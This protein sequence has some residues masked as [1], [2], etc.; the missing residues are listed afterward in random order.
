MADR[1]N[2][3]LQGQVQNTS[4]YG[5]P[6]Q[7]SIT[8]QDLGITDPGSLP[9]TNVNTGINAGTGSFLD[10]MMGESAFGSGGFMSNLP[11]YALGALSYLDQKKTNKLNR[12]VTNT[13]LARQTKENADYDAFRNSW[14]AGGGTNARPQSAFST[15][16]IG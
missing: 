14:G 11:G 3:I 4:N 2:P 15:N 7:E 10:N 16:T 1:I 9:Y 5:T 6:F 12:K 13:N 8:S